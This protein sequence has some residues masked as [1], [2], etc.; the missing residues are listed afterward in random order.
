M[1]VAYHRPATIDDLSDIK[2]FGP[3]K[4]EKYGGAVVEVV[5]EST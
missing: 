5:R 4:L 2:G 3:V 1:E